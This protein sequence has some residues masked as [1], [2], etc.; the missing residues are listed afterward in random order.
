[1]YVRACAMCA[2]TRACRVCVCVRVCACV[3]VCVR[4]CVSVSV[5]DFVCLIGFSFSLLSFLI[6]HCTV[7]VA[8]FDVGQSRQKL[9]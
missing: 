6:D 1:M 5:C 4:V 9:Q 7:F 2:C 8:I 3:C